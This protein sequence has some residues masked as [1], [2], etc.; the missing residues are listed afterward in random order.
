MLVVD[1]D[2]KKALRKVGDENS[3]LPNHLAKG[4]KNAL[5]LA[6]SSEMHTNNL[7]ACEA[8]TRLFVEAIGHYRRYIIS[9]GDDRNYVKL[10][11]VSDNHDPRELL[12]VKIQNF[13]LLEKSFCT[14]D[15]CNFNLQK[16]AFVKA[17]PSHQIRMFL[18]W[19]VETAAFAVFINHRLQSHSPLRGTVVAINLIS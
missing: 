3:I 1:L 11:Q 10:F 8:F 2:E 12:T 14:F 16:E 6:H 19:F 15:E 17:A 9:S 13:N 7:L 5:Q 4:L 18:E